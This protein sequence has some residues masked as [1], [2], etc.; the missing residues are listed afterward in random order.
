MPLNAHSYL[1]GTGLAYITFTSCSESNKSI[2]ILYKCLLPES[3]VKYYYLLNGIST[4]KMVGSCSVINY[5][6]K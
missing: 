2:Y 6:C 5:F 3:A 1:I 4:G